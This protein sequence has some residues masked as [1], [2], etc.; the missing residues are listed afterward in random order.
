MNKLITGSTRL[1]GIVGD[2]VKQVRA[3]EVWTSLF[4]LNGIDAVCVPMH[5]SPA[6]FSSFI[7][8]MK[9]MHNLIG[10][11]ITVPHKP[12][13]ASLVQHL[14]QRARL[15]GAANV[16]RWNADGELSGDITDGTGF[17]RGM[18]ACGNALQGKRVLIVGSGGVG[19]A[20][21]LAVAQADCAEIG[22]SD[23]SRDRAQILC[24]RIR[25]TGTASHIV[26]AAAEGFDVVINGTPIGMRAEDPL[27]INCDRLLASTVVADVIMAPSMTKLLTVARDR[28]CVIHQGTHMMDHSIQEMAQFF[29]L[30]GNDWGIEAVARMS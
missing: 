16:L 10:L 30:D 13:A 7:S 1:L 4:R 15:V 27:P 5:V 24:D 26:P 29:Q 18:L 14:A 19:T 28:G 23:V 11:I 20:I 22:V 17:V 6:K 8:A 12:V 3:P 9:S 21:A 25:A 2:P